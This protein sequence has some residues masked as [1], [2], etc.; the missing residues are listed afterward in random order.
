M[1]KNPETYHL[2][3][4]QGHQTEMQIRKEFKKLFQFITEEEEARLSALRHEKKK[5][6]DMVMEKIA[7]IDRLHTLLSQQVQNIKDT[8]GHD[9][10]LFLHVCNL[11]DVFRCT[12]LIRIGG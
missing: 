11:S 8:L 2:S 1:R 7:E 12:L 9:E 4:S 5:K 3:Q 10:S 6:T